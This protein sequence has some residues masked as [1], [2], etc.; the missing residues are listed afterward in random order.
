MPNHTFH[1]SEGVEALTH[2]APL[3]PR[4]TH[5]CAECKGDWVHEGRCR[6][7]RLAWCPWCLPQA[8]VV[9]VT[10]TE[11][12]PHMHLCQAC[13]QSWRH[14]DACVAPHR[15]AHTGC[16]AHSEPGMAPP[17]SSEPASVVVVG[18][19]RTRRSR[20]AP[21]RRRTRKTSYGLGRVA[22]VGLL[23][24]PIAIGLSVI[25]QPQ[26]LSFDRELTRI[27][28][29]SEDPGR[30]DATSEGVTSATGKA[31][32]EPADSF[33]SAKKTPVP[34]TSGVLEDRQ[35]RLPQRAYVPPTRSPQDA[36]PRVADPVAPLPPVPPPPARPAAPRAVFEAADLSAPPGRDARSILAS[37]PGQLSSPP[38]SQPEPIAQRPAALAAPLPKPAIP[39][40][41]NV[42]GA[43]PAPVDGRGRDDESRGDVDAADPAAIID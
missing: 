12:G 10:G 35:V 31:T 24:A 33:P 2:E 3:L 29:G 43:R 34:A 14:A 39:G 5:R 23:L 20:K 42:V 22:A 4:H 26:R 32:R 30:S 19:A 41:P 6:G 40:P 15:T 28:P 36:G 9:P 1:P 7:G 17:P 16:P 38:Q 13:G 25:F 11:R 8:G 37:P 27:L 18:G 21:S